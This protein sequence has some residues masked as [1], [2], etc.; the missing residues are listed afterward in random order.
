MF[1]AVA[2]DL[3]SRDHQDRVYS[4]L[5]EYGFKKVHEGLYESFT[6][7]DQGLLRLKK[8]LDRQTDSYDSLRFYQYPMENTLVISVLK[9]KKWRK[10]VVSTGR[11][12]QT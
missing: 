12:R 10:T 8:E 3:G 11:G 4:S 1:V 5:V 7:N 2:C 6:I 9:E